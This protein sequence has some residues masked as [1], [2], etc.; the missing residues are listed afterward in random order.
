MMAGRANETSDVKLN[1]TYIRGCAV[2]IATGYGLDGRGVKV[3]VLIGTTFSPPHD[4]Q[5]GSGVHPDFYTM[6]NRG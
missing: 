1:T 2:G 4:V 5:T 3:L 6:G